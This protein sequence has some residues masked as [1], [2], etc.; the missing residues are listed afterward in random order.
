MKILTSVSSLT[1]TCLPEVECNALI[2]SLVPNLKPQKVLIQALVAQR[3]R[4]SAADQGWGSGLDLL[5]RGRGCCSRLKLSAVLNGIKY[6]G[7]MEHLYFGNRND[8]GR[9]KKVDKIRTFGSKNLL[10][11]LFFFSYSMHMIL[12]L[13]VC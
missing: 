4:Q 8:P 6:A 5:S 10:C 1:L 13:F 12:K 3:G 2:F 7:R 11:S 9:G